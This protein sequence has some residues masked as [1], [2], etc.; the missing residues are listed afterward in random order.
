MCRFWKL[1]EDEAEYF[2]LLV[3]LA[4]AS[5]PHLKSIVQRRLT[6]LKLR[7]EDL[8][9]RFNQAQTLALSLIHL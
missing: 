9:Q 2:L 8:S 7:T 3:S 6:E 4:R 1:D 5:S